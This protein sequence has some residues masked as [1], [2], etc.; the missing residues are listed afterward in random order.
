MEDFEKFAQSLARAAIVAAVLICALLALTGCGG[1]G[2]DDEDD[3]KVD[4]RPVQCQ[5]HPELCK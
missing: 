4:N 3:P 2:G 1:G 5:Q